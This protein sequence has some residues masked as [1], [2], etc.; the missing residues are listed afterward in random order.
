MRSVLNK[1]TLGFC[2]ECDF[3]LCLQAQ[4][5]IA[6]FVPTL[7]AA[8]L[9]VL[10]VAAERDAVYILR[11]LRVCFACIL[12]SSDGL[13]VATESWLSICNGPLHTLGASVADAHRQAEPLVLLVAAAC[14]QCLALI[15]RM[16]ALFS[17]LPMS[18]RATVSSAH[19]SGQCGILV[20]ACGRS[21]DIQECTYS[22][23]ESA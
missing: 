4:V 18:R 1:R 16:P 11:C 17:T 15:K 19:K 9:A 14:E 13:E 22:V 23:Q 6:S 2:P 20:P 21:C 5:T 10:P 7:I 12:S 8:G 3:I